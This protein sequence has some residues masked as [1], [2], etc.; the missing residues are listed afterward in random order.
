MNRKRIFIILFTIVVV[1]FSAAA[2]SQSAMKKADRY[3]NSYQY[4]QAAKLYKKAA[5]GTRKEQAL[6]KLGDCYRQMK[7]FKE[8]ESVYAKLVAQK[9]TD[10]S[11]YYY[12]AEA[13]LYNKKYEESSKQLKAYL[14]MKPNDTKGKLMLRAS[15]EMKTWQVQVSAYKVYPLNDVN[16]PYSEFSPFLYNDG[17]IY[18]SE[19]KSDQI[20]AN[21]SFWS[22]NPNLCVFYAKGKKK[23]DSLTFS[24]G[25]PFSAM[26]NNDAQNGPLVFN[27]DKTEACYT[28]VNY[29]RKKQKGFVNRPK[30]YLVSFVNG[31][32]KG[33]I[34]FLY[35][36]DDY[37]VGHSAYAPDGKM[38]YF[39][40]NMPGGF[41]GQDI[42]YCKKDGAM[43]AKPVN[44]GSVIN[45]AGDETFPHVAPDGVFYFSSNGHIGFGGLDIFSSTMKDGAWQRPANMQHPINSTSDDF[46]IFFRDAERGYFASDRPG[47]GGDDLYGFFQTT[48]KSNISGKILLSKDTK[49]AG[50]NMQVA[51][52]NE[53]GDVLQTT[54]TDEKGSFVFDHMPSDKKY[55]V[56]IDET[57]N[58][59]LKDKYYMADNNNRIVRKTVLGQKGIFVFEPLPSDLTKL[60]KLVEEDAFISI[61]G[62][63]LIGEEKIPLVNASVNVTNDKGE[64]VQTTTTNAFGSFVFVDLPSEEN[65]LIAINEKDADLTGKKIYFVNKSGKEIAVS[66]GGFKYRILSSDKTALSLLSVKDADLRIDLK[67]K[68]LGDNNIPLTN[69]KVLV[70][71]EK[72][73]V[74]Q[75]AITDNQG[76]FIFVSL[77]ADKKYLVQIDEKDAAATNFKNLIVVD[78]KG[79][80][81]GKF[82]LFS[83]K[84]KWEMLPSEQK[85][86]ANIYV[87][88]PWLQVQKFKITKKE[89]LTIIENIYY[90]YSKW[91]L[92]AEGKLTLD[93]VVRVMKENTEITIELSSHTDSRSNT[94]F[95][96]KLSDKRAKA[97]VDYM[98]SKGID[99]K[100]LVGKG[101]GE[102]KLINRCNDGIECSEEEHAQNR[103]TEFKIQQKN[104]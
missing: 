77:P 49:D 80:I 39:A 60:T 87:D 10:A 73:E 40:S 78:E 34:P 26:F 93:K 18:A 31:K 99:K 51:L 11:A 13:L 27:A 94:D 24:G 74:V 14:A 23:G 83:G 7:R 81:L 67:G 91:D 41:G 4:A 47:Q 69:S 97:V 6:L 33:E 52:L 58:I 21:V 16:T 45:T 8:A 17:L 37:S 57:D 54:T 3:Y 82:H 88:D 15:D 12:F 70:V 92:L 32:A 36:S 96:Q 65:Y 55:F 63:L 46:G 75:T 38:L 25:S 29:V 72:G 48:E 61:A 64:V 1:V 102:S 2:S 30:M 89:E 35:N 66:E 104:K 84:F 100:R 79:K 68:I 20:A 43:W 53:K 44:A 56:R 71:N 59:V 86:L 85:T 90:E 9:T 62:N 19:S 28:R 22:G 76:G 50:A 98:T 101:Y 42:W 5:V 103:R 95:N